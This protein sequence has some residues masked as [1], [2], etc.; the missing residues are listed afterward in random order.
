M[1]YLAWAIP[2]AVAVLF[3]L[4]K[5]IRQAGRIEEG[6]AGLYRDAKKQD[7]RI[8]RIENFIYRPSSSSRR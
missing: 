3:A 4:F 6:V 5:I 2:S 1:S 8:G 7:D